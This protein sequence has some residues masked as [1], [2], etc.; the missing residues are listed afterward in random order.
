MDYAPAVICAARLARVRLCKKPVGRSRQ[1]QQLAQGEVCTVAT[2]VRQ[3]VEAG[4]FWRASAAASPTTANAP[5]MGDDPLRLA[6]LGLLQQRK[7]GRAL[8]FFEPPDSRARIESTA[9]AH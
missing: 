7:R 2:Q 4:P 8:M 1:A 6:E 9:S 5:G 3:A